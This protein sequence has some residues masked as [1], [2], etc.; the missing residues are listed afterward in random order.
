MS[1]FA[2]Y[3]DEKARPDL[4]ATVLRSLAS[5]GSKSYTIETRQNPAGTFEAK[6]YAD[7]DVATWKNG[8]VLVGK[9]MALAW[10]EAVTELAKVNEELKLVNAT[11][12]QKRAKLG[13]NAGIAG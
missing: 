4:Q 5:R 9:Q 12:L 6:M 7:G 3:A 2:T 8:S 13:P 10:E 11:Y 1:N